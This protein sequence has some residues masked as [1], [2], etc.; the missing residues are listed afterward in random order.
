MY[1]AKSLAK[2][3]RR[4]AKVLRPKTLRA[5]EQQ[6]CERVE[7]V[8]RVIEQPAGLI[9][10][11]LNG[12][13]QEI[14]HAVPRRLLCPPKNLDP[15]TRPGCRLGIAVLGSD[16]REK[17]TEGPPRGVIVQEQPPKTMRLAL[18][19]HWDAAGSS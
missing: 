12:A 9:E 14:R 19:P 5:S 1:F 11:R 8:A 15:I 18:P 10:V 2:E 3:G 16:P 7:L 4:A 6:A 17:I 13:Y